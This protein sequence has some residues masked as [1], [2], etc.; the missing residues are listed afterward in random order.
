MRRFLFCRRFCYFRCGI[1]LH[2]YI[3]DTLASIPDRNSLLFTIVCET[4]CNK[5]LAFSGQDLHYVYTDPLTPPTIDIRL[6]R[7]NAR[8]GRAEFIGEIG[9]RREEEGQKR[10]KDCYNLN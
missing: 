2:S 6:T 4:D 3:T 7:A 10:D 1:P 9:T 5:A 8:D